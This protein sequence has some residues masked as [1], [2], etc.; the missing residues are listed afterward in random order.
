[1]DVEVKP[2]KA[3]G[4]CHV[5]GKSTKLPIHAECGKSS[6]SVEKARLR[7]GR[8]AQKQYAKGAVPKFAVE[9]E[10]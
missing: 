7:K 8:A 9:K 1:M 5:C 6:V 2:Y 10:E 4:T 3:L